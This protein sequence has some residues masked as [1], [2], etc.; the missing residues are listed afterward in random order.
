MKPN[1]NSIV[2][3]SF[4]YAYLMTFMGVKYSTSLRN[5]SQRNVTDK[6]MFYNK[7]ELTDS[8]DGLYYSSN[9]KMYYFK[10]EFRPKSCKGSSPSVPVNETWIKE[11]PKSVLTN[12]MNQ[13]INST[14]ENFLVSFT[15]V[16]RTMLDF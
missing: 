6:T 4:L 14:C 10:I 15:P 2:T 9:S 3:P 8:L 11:N 13:T 1:L 16:L 12:N 5:M 7:P